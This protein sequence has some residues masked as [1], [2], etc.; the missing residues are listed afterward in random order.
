LTKVRRIQKVTATRLQKPEDVMNDSKIFKEGLEVR[1]DV[2]G[3]D[4]VDGAAE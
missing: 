2:L 1:R 4:Y 3:N